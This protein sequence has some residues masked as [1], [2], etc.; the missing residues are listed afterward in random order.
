MGNATPAAVR[1]A[2]HQVAA[3]DADGWAEAVERF[4]LGGEGVDRKGGEGQGG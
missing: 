1:A 2:Q 4:V 3:N